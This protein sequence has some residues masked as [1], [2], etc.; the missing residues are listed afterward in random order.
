[1]DTRAAGRR[2]RSGVH[3]HGNDFP[4]MAE[5]DHQTTKPSDRARTEI[6]DE[7]TV[8]P[9]QSVPDFARCVEVQR[10]IWGA[11]FTD[12][13]PA[14]LLQVSQKVG[15]VAAGAFTKPH[16]RLVG[17]VYGLTG[18]RR[19]RSVHWSHML[20]VLPEYRSRG[21]GEALK[22]FQRSWVLERGVTEMLWT[23]DPLIAGNA[24]FNLNVLGVDIDSYELE[25]Y[26]ETGSDLHSFGTDRFVAR[27]RL[28]G[29]VLAAEGARNE[30][31]GASGGADEPAGEGPS[32]AEI[33]LANVVPPSGEQ[34]GLEPDEPDAPRVR[35]EI[36]EHILE[37]HRKDPELARA[38]R[39]S[40][41]TAFKR[42]FTKGYRIAGFTRI[43]NPGRGIYIL[44]R[45]VPG[46]EAPDA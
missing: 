34:T 43:T 35:V 22:H 10:R 2:S 33:P 12:V 29:E 19:A 30:G 39:A 38:W 11:D 40:T 45:G 42:L 37:V 32:R 23:F 15:G 18:V 7:V 31:R 25:M 3:F 24:H 44:E 27:W 4:H 36:P 17:F 16:A 5:R 46:G 26:G 41:R 14:S 9:L 20:G 1:M 8:R 13:V 28:S 21:I 6:H